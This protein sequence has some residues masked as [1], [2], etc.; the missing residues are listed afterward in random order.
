[1][2]FNPLPCLRNVFRAHTAPYTTSFLSAFKIFVRRFV[3]LQSG[4]LTPWYGIAF[5]ITGPLLGNPPVADEFSYQRA[6]NTELWYFLLLAWPSWQTVKLAVLIHHRPTWHH[7]NGN[8]TY[9]H[10]LDRISKKH[11]TITLDYVSQSILI[12]KVICDSFTISFYALR[13]VNSR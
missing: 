13:Q 1:M 4:M 6:S 11:N 9:K 7:C 8:I 10:G 12:K 2:G 5:H 3:N